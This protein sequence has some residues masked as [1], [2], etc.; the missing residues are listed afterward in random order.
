MDSD[1]SK[2]RYN[3]IVVGGGMAGLSAAENL[4]ETSGG[5]VGK[6]LVLEAGLR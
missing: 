6:L 2:S 3:V 4:V 5:K 1:A